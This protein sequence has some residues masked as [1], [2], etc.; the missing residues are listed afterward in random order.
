MTL[1][2][3]DVS[4][5]EVAVLVNESKPAGRYEAVWDGHDK[6]GNPAATGVYFY[7]LIAGDFA[8]TRKVVLMK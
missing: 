7:R 5:R 8:G 6:H 1:T 2:I 4:G 3:Y